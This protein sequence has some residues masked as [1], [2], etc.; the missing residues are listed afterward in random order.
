MP[1]TFS[2]SRHNLPL[3]YLETLLSN[4]M[5]IMPIRILWM[6]QT[7]SNAQISLLT[8]LMFF[9][10]VIFELPTGALADLIGK[11]YTLISGHLTHVLSLFFYLIAGNVW[12]FGAAVIIQ[13]LAESLRSGADN[14]LVYDS[15]VQ[16]NRED[17][18]RSVNNK[19]MSLVQI[20][21]V[22]ASFMGGWL[23]TVNLALPFIAYGLLI[24]AGLVVTI[25]IKE[26]HVDTKIFSLQSYRQQTI[27]GTKHLFRHSLVSKLA[28]LYII[29]GGVGWTFQRLLRD[30]ILISVGYQEFALGIISGTLRLINIALLVKLAKSAKAIANGWDIV[31]L[32]ILMVLTYAG[33][34][35]LTQTSS[36]AVAAGIMMIG[37]GRFI[38]LM[39][40][41]QENVQSQFRATAISAAN[42]LVSIIL[43]ISMVSLSYLFEITS[44]SSIMLGFSALSLL[45]ILPLS[46]NIRYHL[47][48]ISHKNNT[49]SQHTPDS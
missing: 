40:Y 27:Q 35:W 11:K 32:P 30:M 2:I 41:V 34:L 17:E 44:L 36:I 16:D 48:Q 20:A 39:P 47:K 13:G 18:F 24:L 28:L 46:I 15:L 43:G 26:P 3:L 23:G 19:V 42:M 1:N 7:I 4:F 37:T 31:F 10:I 6:Q 29:V 12:L 21:F 5:L 8:G 38:L 33:G 22:A 9:S 25:K 14:A 49:Q 45:L